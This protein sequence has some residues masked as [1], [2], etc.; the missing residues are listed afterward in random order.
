MRKGILFI[1]SMLGL[2]SLIRAQSET[3]SPPEK[4]PPLE[5]E[6]STPGGFYSTEVILELF[7]PGAIIYYTS[8]GNR[9]FPDKDYLYE[10]PILI[11]STTVIRAIAVKDRKRS[12]IFGHTY[13]L[14][15]PESTFPTISIAYFFSNIL[16]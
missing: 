15:E 13:F 14:N 2:V 11:D 7:A 9:P 16:F 5:V 4:E 3:I 10:G 12:N 8:D 1:I 6:F